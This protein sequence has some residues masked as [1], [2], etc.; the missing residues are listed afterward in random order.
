MG[1]PRS[2]GK[3]KGGRHSTAPEK[4]APLL[5]RSDP[6]I[7]TRMSRDHDHQLKKRTDDPTTIK[8]PSQRDRSL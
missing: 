2:G 8:Q 1:L 6:R 5:L 4:T 7:T 3:E